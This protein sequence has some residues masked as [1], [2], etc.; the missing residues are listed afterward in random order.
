MAGLIGDTNVLMMDGTTMS[1]RDGLDRQAPFWANSAK[2]SVAE[3]WIHVPDVAIVID[4]GTNVETLEVT[5][6]DETTFRCTSDTMIA[7][8]E[9]KHRYIR[10]FDSCGWSLGSRKI[11]ALGFFEFHNIY[12]LQ[13]EQ[14]GNFYIKV[15]TNKIL[16]RA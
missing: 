2:Y 3:G 10:A 16:I 14:Y 12:T 13:V 6:D 9:G 4:V 7:L 8:P 5:L 15:G 1:L 11:V